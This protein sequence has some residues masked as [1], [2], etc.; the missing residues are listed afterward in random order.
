MGQVKYD[1]VGDKLRGVGG[2]AHVTCM[3]LLWVKQAFPNT[4]PIYLYI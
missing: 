4:G 2:V 3:P 1:M